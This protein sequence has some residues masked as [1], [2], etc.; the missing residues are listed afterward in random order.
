MA[1]ALPLSEF[2]VFH[3]EH[4]P[5]LTS[6]FSEGAIMLLDKPKGWSSFDV[7]KFIRGRIKVKKTGHAGTLDPMAT[8]LLILCCGKAT[9]SISEIQNMSKTYTGEITFGAATESY[10]AET[11]V[12]ETAPC[13]HITKEKIK[14]TVQ[15]QFIGEIEQVPPMY[16][17]LKVGGK[18]LYKLA[19]KG[20]EVEREAR[21]VNIYAI[22]VLEFNAPQLKIRVRC[23][24]GT[25]IRSLAHDLGHA[26]GTK[27]HL[28][29][30]EREAIGDYSSA[31]ALTPHEF[32]D[33]LKND[34]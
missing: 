2:P 24:K 25:Y 32:G 23:S 14:Q 17:A 10:D 3:K 15:E 9:K 29:A 19:R 21:K 11:E 12:T 26:M 27:A 28:S 22:D 31:K 33:Y 7:V 34:G 30:L 5:Q 8:G 20:I 4:P 18:T 1:K 13:H 6:D 16:S